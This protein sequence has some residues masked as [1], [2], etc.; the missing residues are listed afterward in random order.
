M[1]IK[2]QEILNNITNEDPLKGAITT[3]TDWLNGKPNASIGLNADVA[4]GY[5]L[6][7]DT[8]L[9]VVTQPTVSRIKAMS[10]MI[11]IPFC[12]SINFQEARSITPNKMVG[13]TAM[14]MTSTNTPAGG[15]M[16]IIPTRENNTLS[17]IYRLMKDKP[18]SGSDKF[19]TERNHYYDLNEA[20]FSIPVGLG[21]VYSTK[22]Q[23]SSRNK[24]QKIV[25]IQIAENSLIQSIQYSISAGQATTPESVSFISQSIVGAANTQTAYFEKLSK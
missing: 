16:T 23:R 2:I 1:A 5:S 18:G 14:V 20:L 21:V 25:G 7:S 17:S 12:M 6:S 3:L 22:V 8:T 4:S 15:S 9:P 24:T 11:P 13:T 10:D 19:I